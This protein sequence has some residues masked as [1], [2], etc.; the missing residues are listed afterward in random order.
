MDGSNPI[1]PNQTTRGIGACIANILIL[2]VPVSFRVPIESSHTA[3]VWLYR[4]LVSLEDPSTLF[5][6]E[7]G[8]D[9]FKEL[10][11][12]KFLLRVSL[13]LLAVDRLSSCVKFSETPIGPGRS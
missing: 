12:E 10:L 13:V 5:D 7:R 11:A 4:K 1:Y 8:T 2:Y 3:D 6:T 9:R